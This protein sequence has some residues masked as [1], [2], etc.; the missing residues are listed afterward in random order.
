MKDSS[1]I[2]KQIKNQIQNDTQ[3]LSSFHKKI[4]KC[5]RDI[6]SYF[7]TSYELFKISR[8]YLNKNNKELDK[9]VLIIFKRKIKLLLD[10]VDD[11]L[12]E[13]DKRGIKR[14]INNVIGNQ[15]YSKQ[16]ELI[17]KQL[18]EDK[19]SEYNYKTVQLYC[20]VCKRYDDFDENDNYF[21]CD[22]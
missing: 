6:A 5:S 11:K 3:I 4:I 22:H 10:D 21:S 19:C 14:L 17:F 8:P 12:S 16:A 15:T 13:S 7:K 20:R 18:L 1:S 2:K 9:N